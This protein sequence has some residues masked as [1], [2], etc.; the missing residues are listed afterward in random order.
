MIAKADVFVFLDDVQFTSRDWR[1]R[2]Q[3]KS[4]DGLRWLTIPVGSSRERKICEVDLPSTTWMRS[5]HDIVSS[6]YKNSI[7]FDFG[8]ELLAEIYR[9]KF[10]TL[11]EFN[12]YW[13]RYI[14]IEVLGLS[15][16]F[17]DSRDV[18]NSG[19]GS[20]KILS[21]CKALNATKYLSGPSASNYLQLETF[22]ESDIDV[23]YADYS[24]LPLHNQL[25]GDFLPNLSILD[26]V[27]NENS[28]LSRFI[29]I[30]M[31]KT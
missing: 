19:R 10:K 21:I 6:A 27:F 11:S 12:Q 30:D 17:K 28:D 3:I 22:R 16:Q 5:H 18:P 24:R 7:N 23:Y 13:I 29:E 26:L 15:C 20:E 14:A 8:M 25:H 9:P 1:S 2:N 4:Q 31:I